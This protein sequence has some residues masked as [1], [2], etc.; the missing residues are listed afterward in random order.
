MKKKISPFKLGLFFLVGAGV[1]VVGLV[2]IGVAHFFENRN[3]YVT[4][5]D[6]PVGG[7]ETGAD[8]TRLGI[9]V[10]RITAIDLLDKKNLVRVTM[11]IEP[12][13]EMHGMVVQSKLAGLTGGSDLAIVPA[14]DHLSAMTPLVDFP[15]EHPV[16]PSIPG[17][18][19]KI[20]KAV[21]AVSDQLQDF[22][23]QGVLA[24]WTEVGQNANKLLT[25]KDIDRALT[26]L[27]TAAASLRRILQNLAQDG[28]VQAL[29]RGIEDLAA[30]AA[31]AR[32]AG[33]AIS[34]QMDAI[35]PGSLG[36]TAKKMEQTATQAD[37]VVGAMRTELPQTLSL[38]QQ[39]VHELN[40]VLQEL[41][42]L[43]QSLREEPGRILDRPGGSEPFGR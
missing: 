19:T 39:A 32:R 23:T 33:A 12:R 18:L 34:R 41:D 1:A 27:Q 43:V 11:K 4:F 2:W 15:T 20:K 10:G 26:D 25:N 8:I 7:L 16:V 6:E 37:Q 21:V 29:N 28:T 24:A 14:P 35:P 13:I 22:D 38:V 9:N 3:T 30:A 17:M 42:G 31:Q 36:D 40:Q 5:F